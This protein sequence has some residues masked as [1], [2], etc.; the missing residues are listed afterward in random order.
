MYCVERNL[1]NHDRL[2]ERSFCE[3]ADE[4]L[5]DSMD[6]NIISFDELQIKLSGMH[7][8]LA[9]FIRRRFIYGDPISVPIDTLDLEQLKRVVALVRRHIPSLKETT[10]VIL[11]DEYEN[12]FPYQ[13]RI[14][15]SLLKLGPPHVSVKIAKKLA[16]GDVPGTTTGQELQEIHDYT[17]VPLVYNVGDSAERTPTTNYC[18]TS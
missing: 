2:V 16:S 17:R 4:L 8:R 11:L 3:E 7:K 18:A 5:F 12:L 1:I 9:A 15:N 10:F 13:K 14:V 6:R